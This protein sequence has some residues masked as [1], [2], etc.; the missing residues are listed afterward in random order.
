MMFFFS[1]PMLFFAATAFA[2][3]GGGGEQEAAMGLVPDTKNGRDV[4][5][6]CARCH[7]T[8][9]W[10]TKDGRFPQLAGQHR[11]VLIKQLADIRAGNRDNPTM[12]PFALPES[13]GGAQSVADVVAYIQGLPMNPV[14]GK[15]PWGPSTPEY[16]QGRRLYLETCATCHK[17]RGEGSNEAFYPRLQGQHYRYML[18][19]IKWIREGKR[20]NAN[21]EMVKQIQ[22]FSEQEMR[23]MINFVSRIP[24][25]SSKLAPSREWK[26][27]DFNFPR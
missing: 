6:L 19:Q 5:E 18:R 17:A 4:Y 11:N 12:Y 22:G 16:E 1:L 21:P 2:W 8:E 13:I 10:G 14:Q 15:G 3:N 7:G 24:V 9:G 25:A 23:L 27:P 26:N 20:R